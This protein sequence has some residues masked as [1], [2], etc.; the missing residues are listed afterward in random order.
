MIIIDGVPVLTDVYHIMLTLQRE[1]RLNG[2]PLLATIKPPREGVDLMVTCPYHKH[3]ME[4][5]PSCGITTIAKPNVP[6]GT[7]YCF[8]CKTTA[9]L[10][11]VVSHCFGKH[12]GGVFGRNWIMEHFVSIEENSRGGFFTVPTREITKQEHEYVPEEE[13][14][15]YRFVHPYLYKRGMTDELIEMFDLGYDRQ[16][17]MVTFPIKDTNGKVLFVAKR[18]VD[19]KFFALPKDLEKPLCYLYEAKKYFPD[20]KELYICES[21]FNALTMVKYLK[22]PCVALLGT[23]T[24]HQIDKLKYLGYRRY[25]LCLDNDKAGILGA[26]KLASALKTFALIDYMISPKGMDINDIGVKSKDTDEF[27]S[28]FNNSIGGG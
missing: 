22:M 16:K 25:I 23:G 20:S 17:R 13:L 8:S 24:K 15:S 27:I 6:V 9:S 7:L 2:S 12:D 18:S 4:S 11:E 14:E 26:K 21:L 10:P 1:L 5:K 28:Y 19:T 3:G